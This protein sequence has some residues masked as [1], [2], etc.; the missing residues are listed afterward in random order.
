MGSDPDLAEGP[1]I[2]DALGR[3]LAP[4]ARHADG[5]MATG[6]ETAAA[7]LAH[8]GIDGLRLID[9]TEPGVSLGVTLGAFTMPIVTKAGAF[10]DEGTLLRAL[11]RL[12]AIH[13]QGSLS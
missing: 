6:G 1:A 13:R 11:H 4:A 10:G 8:C 12:R 9:E 5:L 3:L 7:L 2:A